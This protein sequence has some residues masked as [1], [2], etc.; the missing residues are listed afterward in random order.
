MSIWLTSKF[1]HILEYLEWQSNQLDWEQNCVNCNTSLQS[2]LRIA[3]A[4]LISKISRLQHKTSLTFKIWKSFLPQNF[5]SWFIVF[6]FHHATNWDA[7][8]S[9]VKGCICQ[10]LFI[11]LDYKGVLFNYYINC[12][13]GLMI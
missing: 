12:A 3:I 10:S 11:Q 2:V 9:R 4:M 13:I 1:V 8:S 6:F 5:L 7:I